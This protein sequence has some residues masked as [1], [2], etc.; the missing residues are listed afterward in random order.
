MPSETDI[1]AA[2]AARRVPIV[3]QLA[4]LII[5]AA[6][7]LVLH[8]LSGSAGAELGSHPDEAAHFVTGLMVRDYLA[9]GGHGSPMAFG[10]EYY[11]HYPKIGLGNWPPLFYVVQ[12]AWTVVFPATVRSVLYLMA[13]LGVAVEMKL[14]WWLW[15]EFGWMEAVAGAVMLVGLPLMQEYSNMVM[16]EMLSALLMFAA[17]GFFARWLEGAPCSAVMNFGVLAGLAIMNKGTGLALVFVPP[18]AILMTGRWDL[19]KRGTLWL[20]ALVAGVIAGPWTWHFRNAGKGG[21]EEANPSVHFTQ[22]AV[23]YYAWQMVVALGWMIGG[24]A[25]IGAVSLFLPKTRKPAISVC[26]L[27]L[28]LG[29][30]IFQSLT[31]VGREARHL[32]PAMP[33]LMVLAFTGVHAVTA[34]RPSLRPVF[35]G[36]MLAIY[37]ICPLFFKATNPLPGY[38][39]L[40]NSARLSPFR[41]PMKEWSGFESIVDAVLANDPNIPVLVASDARGEGMFIAEL[42]ERDVHRP[43]FTVLRA[44]KLLATSTWSGSGYESFYQT[45]EQVRAAIAKSG[46][47]Y[48]VTDGSPDAMPPHDKLLITTISAAG[49]NEYA[50]V[51]SADAMRDGHVSRSAINLYRIQPGG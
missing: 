15:R 25:L 28:V 16:A 21:W 6:M 35:C 4:L 11:K 9:S 46:A 14:A 44:S 45:P 34:G 5:V 48:V 43:S 29:V 41:I 26:S 38:G 24:L 22:M 8:H 37:F 12:A 3:G 32:A 36:A 1:P 2:T 23:G 51:R 49:A 19:L 30:W 17:V 31:P 18:I 10:S 39:S 33:A 50:P 42:A 47:G 40:G 7:V 20:A 27:A 13:L